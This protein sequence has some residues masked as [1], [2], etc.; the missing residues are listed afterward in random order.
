MRTEESGESARFQVDPRANAGGCIVVEVL[1]TRGHPQSGVTN[2]LVF[3][4]RASGFDVL[5]FG[6]QEEGNW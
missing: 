4:R 1:M 2:T 3:S 5:I 6:P